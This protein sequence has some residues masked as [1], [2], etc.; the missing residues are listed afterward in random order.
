MKKIYLLQAGMLLTFFSCTNFL[1]QDPQVNPAAEVYFQDAK[2]AT[3][4]INACYAP[5]QQLCI[6]QDVEYRSGVDFLAEAMG[7]DIMPN[8]SNVQMMQVHQGQP[9]SSS[10]TVRTLWVSHYRNIAYA[11]K[12]IEMIPA[13]DMDPALRNR[14]KAEALFLRA[15]WYLRLAKFF[16]TVPIVQNT[17]Q[18]ELYNVPQVSQDSVFSFAAK[19]LKEAISYLPKRYSGA[20]VGRATKGAARAYLTEVYLWKKQWTLAKEQLDSIMTYSYSLAP[21]YE[22]L[23]NGKNDNSTESI[24]EVQYEA[25]TGKYL[26]NLAS[27]QIGP[28]TQPPITMGGGW[29]WMNPSRDLYDSYETTP[30]VDPRRTKSILVKGDIFYGKTVGQIN[31]HGN[32]ANR[33]FIVPNPDT[34]FNI[35][36]GMDRSTFGTSANYILMRYAEILLFY[37]EVMNELG[38]QADASKYLNL[39]R[40]RPDVALEPIPSTLTYEQMAEKIRAERRAELCL[41]G[42]RA[43]DLRRWGIAKEFLNSPLRW[44]NNISLYPQGAGNYFKYVSNFLPIPQLEIDRSMGVLKQHNEYTSK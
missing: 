40:A 12:A 15:F 39:V 42:K 24:F 30:K 1:E 22:S 7:S 20:D 34:W 44:Q 18:P 10:E 36:V 6:W 17:G 4:G 27:R 25:N 26:D 16:G 13:I 23:F 38:K 5:L 19:D 9:P 37:A 43:F 8:Q 2:T 14:L 33:K 29:G 35:G 11:N 41:E 32:L 28:M 3:M 21:D 31:S